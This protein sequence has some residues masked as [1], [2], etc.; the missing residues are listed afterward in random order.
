MGFK[1]LLQFI[2][3]KMEISKETSIQLHFCHNAVQN[4]D[5]CIP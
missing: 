1:T 3:M 4:S 2:L 5:F